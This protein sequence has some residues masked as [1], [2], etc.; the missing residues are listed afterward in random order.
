MAEVEKSFK[1]HP[2]MV[3]LLD[4]YL[5]LAIM[6]EIIVGLIVTLLVYMLDHY[7]PTFQ[8]YPSSF[9]SH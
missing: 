1:P 3:K 7:M 2:N 8:P 6:P 4:Y 9:L 5:L